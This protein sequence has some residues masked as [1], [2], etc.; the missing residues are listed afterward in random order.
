[1]FRIYSRQVA[2]LVVAPFAGLTIA[3]VRLYNACHCTPNEQRAT[4]GIPRPAD[5][6]VVTKNDNYVKGIQIWGIGIKED[7]VPGEKR[8]RGMQHLTSTYWIYDMGVFIQREFKAMQTM[9]RY[10]H[11]RSEELEGYDFRYFLNVSNALFLK[12]TVHTDYISSPHQQPTLI[13]T[14]IN[15][16]SFGFLCV[17]LRQRAFALA[18]GV[19]FFSWRAGSQWLQLR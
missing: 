10:A 11:E 6:E 2:A 4:D 19:T 15:H 3:H 1:M 9:M 17:R 16:S 8:G 13:H 7:P 12:V 5:N 14:S 18:M